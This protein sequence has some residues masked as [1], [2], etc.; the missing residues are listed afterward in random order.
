[1]NSSVDITP[2]TYSQILQHQVHNCA[3]LYWEPLFYCALGAAVVT[4]LLFAVFLCNVGGALDC[5]FAA[6][7]KAQRK[8]LA[9]LEDPEAAHSLLPVAAPVP[10]KPP[11]TIHAVPPVGVPVVLPQ[12]PVVLNFGRASGLGGQYLQ[13]RPLSGKSKV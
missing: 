4:G 6:H 7:K 1:M 3:P 12:Q 5:V 11:P 9:N 2:I 10:S 13:T 8:R